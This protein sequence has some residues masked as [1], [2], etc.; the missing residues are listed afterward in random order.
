[1]FTSKITSKGQI[2]IPV[3][4]RKM[5]GTDLVELDVVGEEIVIRPIRKPGGALKKYA[6]KNKSLEEVM[7]LEEEAAKNGFLKED[8]DY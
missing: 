1:M 5:L 6:L 8:N 2:T 7:A 4:L 3:K